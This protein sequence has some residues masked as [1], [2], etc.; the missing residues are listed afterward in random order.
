MLVDDATVAEVDGLLAQVQVVVPAL[1]LTP[2][3]MMRKAATRVRQARHVSSTAGVAIATLTFGWSDHSGTSFGS[4][5]SWVTGPEIPAECWSVGLD[6][7]A[8]QAA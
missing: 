6:Q 4:A 7:L 5:R 1:P 8:L 2:R 3:K